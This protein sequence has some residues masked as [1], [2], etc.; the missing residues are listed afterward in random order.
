[1]ELNIRI[2]RK[3]CW[4]GVKE[5]FFYVQKGCRDPEPMEKHVNGATDNWLALTQLK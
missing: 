3:T 2:L 5:D 1:V 4:G